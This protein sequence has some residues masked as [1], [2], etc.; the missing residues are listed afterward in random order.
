MPDNLALLD[1]NDI[2]NGSSAQD[3]AD[4]GCPFK[5]APTVETV[6]N[7]QNIQNILGLGSNDTLESSIAPDFLNGNTGNDLISGSADGDIG[8]STSQVRIG[9]L[10]RDGSAY[11]LTEGSDTFTIPLGLLDTLIGGLRGLGGAD[12]ITG[13]ESGDIIYGDEGNDRIEG[14]GGNDLLYGGLGNDFLSGGAGQNGLLG[15]AGADTLQ[16]GESADGVNGNAGDDVIFGAG[17]DDFLRGGR[18]ND[19]V[20]GGDGND[21]LIGDLGN[22]TLTGGAGQDL[23]FLRSEAALGSPT[24]DLITDFQRTIDFIGLSTNLKESDVIL[25]SKVQPAGG[26]AVDIKVAATGAL[27]GTVLGVTPDDLKGR[28]RPYDVEPDRPEDRVTIDL[29]EVKKLSD[30]KFQMEFPASDGSKYTV[31]FQDDADG[32]F[33]ESVIFVPNRTTGV[34]GSTTRMSRD[35]TRADVTLEGSN[36]TVRVENQ[37][38][39]EAG[40]PDQGVISRLKDGQIIDTVTVPLPLEPTV[41]TNPQPPVTPP[42]VGPDFATNCEPL[43]KFCEG[44]G[45]V[46][47]VVDFVANVAV[48]TG[49]LFAV[50]SGGT[51]L[52]LDAIGLGLKGVSTAL[53]V[54]DYSCK[55]LT[56][57]DKDLGDAVIDQ[58]KGIGIGK[59]LKSAGLAEDLENA[60]GGTL[61]LS[62]STKDLIGSFGKE[63]PTEPSKTNFLPQIRKWLAEKYNFPFDFC[64]KP[65]TT[66]VT[67]P[68]TPS[69][70]FKKIEITPSAIPYLG[71]ANLNVKYVNPSNNSTNI[72]ISGTGRKGIGNPTFLIPEDK[73]GQGEFNFTLTNIGTEQGG[74]GSA[75]LDRFLDV[76]IGT[77]GG[78]KLFDTVNYRQLSFDLL[79]A[80]NGVNNILSNVYTLSSVEG[81]TRR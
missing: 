60:V 43:K 38:S 3:Q 28:F 67:P 32:R 8:R 53:T 6:S 79:A 49:L 73:K 31:V 45:K 25:E 78:G 65:A 33:V 34:R 71:T 61:D 5:K 27:L 51:S 14:R 52:S 7:A 81:L 58:L 77:G 11:I 59:A 44:I 29:P 76:S 19:I 74:Q 12:S 16:G 35:G 23:F 20:N 69:T 36:E 26:S 9:S 64:D 24:F 10:S 57:S 75:G 56:G 66:P 4:C 50:P 42:P 46:A 13:S 68:P 30:N 17:G 37:P 40:K 1:K 63:E 54:I 70:P 62:S 21:F 2:L 72:E 39:K 18:G 48:V 15:G 41:P 55:L 47:K 80:P 22:D